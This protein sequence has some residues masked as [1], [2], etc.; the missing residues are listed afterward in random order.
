MADTKKNIL[1]MA[2]NQKKQIVL[3]MAETRKKLFYIWLKLEK[4]FK[5]GGK[6]KKIVINM[7]E[8]RKKDS[9]KYG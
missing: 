5:Y 1:N 3:N 9:F 8:T 7:T 6:Q 4:K 2:E